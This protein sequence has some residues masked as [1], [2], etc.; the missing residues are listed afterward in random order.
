MVFN[1]LPVPRD[2]F[3]MIRG[4]YDKPGEKV[5]PGVPAVL[6][7]LKLSDPTKRATRLDLAN[8]IV[9]PE[10]PLTARVAANRLW[11][12][13]FG[14]G[15]VRPATTSAR[16][17]N[18]R[19]TPSCSTGLS[20]EYRV[21]LG[22]EEVR[23]VAGDERRVPARRGPVGGRARERPGQPAAESR[24]AIPARRGAV[25]RQRAVRE[26]ADEPPDGRPRGERRTSRRTSGSRSASATA[27]P[28]TT[29]KTTA[30]RC[31]GGACTCSSSARPRPRS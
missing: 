3:V 1:D 8:W 24:P 27:T 4:Q 28:A 13:F 9:S 2:A 14:T 6:P 21:Q 12:Q 10:N 29:C 30:R 20:S 7:P 22:Y 18:R 23:E 5:T 31:T 26:R 25:A 11:Q 16:R 15:L 19:A 17:A